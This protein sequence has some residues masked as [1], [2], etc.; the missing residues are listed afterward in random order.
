MRGSDH[1]LDQRGLV[2]DQHGGVAAQ[3]LDERG[4]L[5]PA[6]SRSLIAHPRLATSRGRGRLA[7]SLAE[8]RPRP[9]LTPCAEADCSTRRALGGLHLAGHGRRGRGSERRGRR[10]DGGGRRRRPA[11]FDRTAARR[12]A[13]PPLRRKIGTPLLFGPARSAGC[14]DS[15]V[16]SRDWLRARAPARGRASSWRGGGVCARVGRRRP[17]S[18]RGP[19][20]RSCAPGCL[21]RP[22]RQSSPRLARSRASPSSAG[23]C[24]HGPGATSAG[25]APAEARASAGRS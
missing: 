18:L 11:P 9:G 4:E 3:A 6:A 15:R 23:A 20:R 13:R 1:G 24:R 21:A 10:W 12:A 8:P 17:G 2:H 16:A 25:A 14:S 22:A 5:A 19:G 7:P